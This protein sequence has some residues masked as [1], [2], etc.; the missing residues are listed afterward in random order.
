MNT[1]VITGVGVVSPL[2]IGIDVLW[3]NLL[4][5]KTSL[6]HFNDLE[7]A[8][9]RNTS[10]CRVTDFEAPQITRGACM[11]L[12]AAKQAIAQSNI[13]LPKNTGI[14]LGST[15]GESMAYELAAEGEPID[16][17]AYNTFSIAKAIA[18][19]YQVIG[20]IQALSTACTAGNYAVGAA[21][22]ALQRGDID[23]AIAGGAEPF[24]RIAMV[25][26]TRSR[27][28]AADGCKPFDANRTGMVLGEGAA[29][30]IVERLDDAV[31]RGAMTLATVHAL[32]LSCDAYHPT[33]P[34]P[35]GR[36][37]TNAMNAA[38]KKSGINADDIDWVNIHG[39]GT[40]VSD[41]AE[42]IALKNVF[43]NNMPLLSGS[44]GAIGHALGAASALE[45]AICVKGIATQTIPPTPGYTIQDAD[46]ALDCTTQPV[47]K[48]I[49]LVINNA[50][51]FGGL[52]ASLLLGSSMY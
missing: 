35:D 8:G 29:I 7:A 20:P 18:D 40:R 3:N 14:F 39:S 11:A 15:L 2:G 30:F 21:M 45:L 49:N 41:A 16:P 47:H 22:A 9:Y 25:G 50:S 10:A 52:N 46:I 32:G 34:H 51:A 38:F 6:Q 44:K 43:K 4:S 42:S 19:T 48:K 1:I 13:Q 5:S 12:E 37:L 23:V 24:S 26:F 36:G 17:E 28:M 27:A 33:S 31:K